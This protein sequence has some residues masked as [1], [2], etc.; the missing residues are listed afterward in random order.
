MLKEEVLEILPKLFKEINFEKLIIQEA[1]D[2][3][4]G[5]YD[6]KTEE[7]IEESLRDEYDIIIEDSE[8]SHVEI[9]SIDKILSR[10]PHIEMRLRN[11][12]FE[13]VSVDVAPKDKTKE[14]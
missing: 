13:I 1:T 5:D 2:S 10:Y 4:Y 7:V 12:N 3:V 11:G 9:L 6:P 14:G 8:V